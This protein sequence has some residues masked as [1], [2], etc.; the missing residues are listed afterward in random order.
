MGRPSRHNDHDCF[1]AIHTVYIRVGNPAKQVRFGYVCRRCFTLWPAK[2]HRLAVAHERVDSAI[3][4]IEHGKE[5]V[6]LVSEKVRRGVE[7][8]RPLDF[9]H[10]E[11]DKARS[12]LAAAQAALQ[13][14][15]A[16][17]D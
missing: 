3:R 8:F 1:G 10:A 6:G 14:L 5:M 13:Q 17:S 11:L 15:Q 4:N 12:E 2:E 9:Y 16:E 7:P